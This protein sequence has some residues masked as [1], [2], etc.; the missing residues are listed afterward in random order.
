MNCTKC[1]KEIPEG[2]KKV[3]DECQKKL[4]EE[5]SDAEKKEE[6]SEKKEDVKTESKEFKV[7]KEKTKNKLMPYFLICLVVL[8]IIVVFVILGMYFYNRNGV[9]NTIGNIRNYGY[10]TV[11]GNWIY[12]L[13][14]NENSSS[15]GIF[16]IKKDGTDP[17][18]LYMSDGTQEIISIN[19]VGNYVYFIG[20]NTDEYTD[21]DSID[22]KIYRMKTDGSNLEVINDNEINNNCYEM[23]VING[24]IYYIDT[25]ANVAKMNL[26]GSNK[27]V[28]SENGTGFLG[29]TE[30]YIIYNVVTDQEDVYITYIMDINGENQ[31]PIIENRR[32]YSV[33]IE[34]EYIYY[35]NDEKQ[36]CRTKIDSNNEEIISDNE[37]YNLNVNN[38]FAYYLN[39]KDA[40]QDDYTVCIYKI[41][42]NA[43]DKTPVIIKELDTY[44]S[45]LNIVG[46]WALYMDTNEVSGFINLVNIETSEI[47]QLYYLDYDNYYYGEDTNNEA[48]TQDQVTNTDTNENQVSTETQTENTTQIENTENQSTSTDTSNT[49]TNNTIQAGE[50][51]N[52][53]TSNSTTQE[54]STT[55]ENTTNNIATN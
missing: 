1:G 27:T 14:P 7:K 41:D 36:I 55:T 29:I 32:L 38:G 44:S 49:Q 8:I 22:N 2:D 47:V 13:S 12:Y 53:V 26:D 25:N 20:M 3:C 21:D 4:L 6:N 42:L 30:D 15:V 40:A 11:S 54:T 18:Q 16:K 46:N 43:E 35:T 45:F 48:T 19:V 10:G 51:T 37:A 9:G 50:E 52:S 23:Y 33:N 39:Y 17:K 31:R 34:G 5:I 24:Y 28:V